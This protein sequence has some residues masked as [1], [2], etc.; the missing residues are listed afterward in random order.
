MRNLVLIIASMFIMLACTQE[1]S[2]LPVKESANDASA[3]TTAEAQL[4]F[5]KILSAA[6]SKNVEVRKFLKKEALAQFDNDYDVFY[7][8]VKNKIVANN[9]TFRDILL[10]YCDDE[11]ELSQIEKSQLLLNILVPDLTLFWNFNAEKWDTDNNEIA[12]VSR[13]DKSNTMYQNGENIGQM[14][15]EEIPGFPCLVVK[16]N[17]RMKVVNANTR[18]G[19]ATYAFIDEAFDGSKRVEMPTTRHSEYDVTIDIP[20]DLDAGIPASDLPDICIKAWNEL[21]DVP[22]ACQRDYI[23][24]NID[25]NNKP[26]VLNR[27]IRERIYRFRLNNTG[28]YSSIQDQDDPTLTDYTQAK[29]YLTNDE[30]RKKIWTTGN[31]AFRISSYI[32]GDIGA[33]AMEVSKVFPVTPQELFY[34]KKVH[35]KHKNST[36]FRE[37]KN[38]YTVN[39]GDLVPRW[40][41]P[42]KLGGVSNEN[43]VFTEPW[44]L[45][46]KSLTIFFFVEEVDATE[47]VTR[48]KTVVSEFVNKADFSVQGS[49]KVDKIE[50]TAKLGY[51][52]SSTH[53]SSSK[54]SVN[55]S[56]GSDDMGSVSFQ[57]YNP[58]IRNKDS[59]G[60]YTLFSASTGAL[61][62][63]LLPIDTSK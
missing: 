15:E 48:E 30:I 53:T 26:G 33:Q 57:F 31:F 21:K 56:L 58:I 36:M 11:Q 60:N 63:T 4:K 28:T 37:S 18:S 39:K 19:E 3:L 8:F 43:F 12:V 29:R 23:Y 22:N 13:D 49:G 9:Q 14:E 24:Y 10:S 50:L 20:D 61:V 25:K 32:A 52:I 5:A 41:Y 35:L 6:A 62:V 51:G 17:S 46:G 7:P 44:D 34:I 16:N 40:V 54:L 27:N 59:K 1:E 42:E 38:F 45:Y 47:T 55:T 2:V